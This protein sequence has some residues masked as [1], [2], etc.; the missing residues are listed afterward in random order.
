MTMKGYLS[1]GMRGH[2]NYNFEWFWTAAKLLRADDWEIR[3][4]AEFDIEKGYVKVRCQCGFE[5]RSEHEARTFLTDA[6]TWGDSDAYHSAVVTGFTEGKDG[7]MEEIFMNDMAAVAWADAIILGPDWRTSKGA[8]AEAAMAHALGKRFFFLEL[9]ED[10]GLDTMF[11]FEP[12]IRVGYDGPPAIRGVLIEEDEGAEVAWNATFDAPV[13][14]GT[15]N[16]SYVSASPTPLVI[17]GNTFEQDEQDRA[18]AGEHYPYPPV[19]PADAEQLAR[20]FGREVWAEPNPP[21]G[22]ERVGDGLELTGET[23]ITSET[24]GQKGSKIV[25][26]ARIPADMLELLARHYGV[27]AEKYPDPEPGT[28][29]WQLGYPWSL[30]TNAGQRHELAWQRGE[31]YDEETGSHHL[32]AVAWHAITRA[33]FEIHE[34]GT[35]DRYTVLRRAETPEGT[36]T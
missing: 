25:Q 7:V 5:A 30:S 22:F 18:L 35:D 34:V 20:D 9:H 24:G 31:S 21:A 17:E 29:N 13:V 19:K 14:S 33:W 1:N 16:T 32:I 4:P 10:D 6:Y 23:R 11:E 36:E 28:A 27:G 26:P 12:F 2:P 15:V 3:S 8:K